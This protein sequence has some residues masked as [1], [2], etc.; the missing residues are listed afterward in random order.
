MSADFDYGNARVRALKSELL[1]RPQ[2]EE[3]MDL[4]VDRLAAALSDTPYRPDV[5]AATPRYRGV[6]LVHEALRLNLSRTLRRLASWYDDEAAEAVGLLLGRWDLRN[7]RALLRGQFARRPVDEIEAILV[8]AGSIA[9]SILTQLAAQPDLRTTVEMMVVWSVPDS[10]T[11]RAVLAN[12]PDFEAS[13]EFQALERV[14]ERSRAA[15][16]TSTAGRH[17]P[18]LS[19][20]LGAEVDQVNILTVLRLRDEGEER[21]DVV[22]PG[23]RV[24]SGGSIP[25]PALMRAA[26]AD[27]RAGAAA[28]LEAAPTS[29]SGALSRWSES[30]DLV[31]LAHELESEAT[32]AAAGL[33]STADPLGVG[34]PVAYVWAKE[35]EVRNLRTIAAGLDAKLPA[36]MIESELLVLW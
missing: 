34:M 15:Y 22:D 8:P 33:F 4:E 1:T 31:H 26:A 25:L 24:L 17:D 5:L 35:N 11:A 14:L 6:R 13:G 7:V 10:K 16:V 20:V 12:W 27:D 28:A 32:K 18:A 3:L 36:D 30:G 19:G 29:W 21:W 2:Y 9:E 23:E